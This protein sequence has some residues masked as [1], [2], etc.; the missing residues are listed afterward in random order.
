MT[1]QFIQP[2]G[3]F[4][5]RLGSNSSSQL[6]CVIVAHQEVTTNVLLLGDEFFPHEGGGSVVEGNQADEFKAATQLSLQ[7]GQY[8]GSSR[9]SEHHHKIFKRVKGAEDQSEK[10]DIRRTLPSIV[11]FRGGGW[12]HKPR[13]A[14]DHQ[15][16]GIS[17]RAV[18]KSALR[19]LQ[20]QLWKTHV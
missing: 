16:G 9:W 8:P 12:G 13:K 5:I 15:G 2:T 11:G 18:R 14:G 1:Q 3:C 10:C 6:C 17:P 4:F 19:T 7:Q 20:G